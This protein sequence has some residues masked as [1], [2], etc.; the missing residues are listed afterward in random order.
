MNR[1]EFIKK[2][3]TGA[4]AALAVSVAAPAARAQQT[5]DW[6]MATTWPHKFP[7]FQT[8]VERFAQR[9]AQITGGR[10]KIHVYAAGT[11]VPPLG[12]FD[13][14]SSG[15]IQAGS[16]SSYFWQEKVP[17][18][19]WFSTVP[20]GLDAVGMN[21]W[22]YNGEGLKLWEELYAPYDLV[23]R[24]IGN[25]G[26]AM[27]GWFNK[28]IDSVL[29][30]RNMTIRTVGFGAKV[31]AKTG[32]NVVS[33]GGLELVNSLKK[34][35][36]DAAE[37]VGPYHDLR[38]GLYQA[39]KYY[40]YPGWQSPGLCLEAIF[41]KKAYEELPED[42]KAGLDMA[43]MEAN[44][45]ALTEFEANNRAATFELLKKHKVNFIPFPEK[46]LLSL[47]VI[48]TEVLEEEA[49][50]DANSK[51]ISDAYTKFLRDGGNWSMISGKAY[52][53]QVLEPFTL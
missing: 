30:F 2:T 41:N 20:F 27:G 47:R 53:N 23:P 15:K 22:L 24:P 46:V 52:Y 44:M 10:L 12:V 13:A 11:L 16:G 31:L 4:A 14:V 51:L 3:G 8:G 21:A 1:R 33:S 32:V 45:A 43:V 26:C 35:R 18:A 36:I 34:G 9:V 19:Q 39:A 17:A 7:I 28:E 6:K 50:K 37:W 40:Y 38:L 42:L 25:T 5:Y 49:A 29:A 48:A